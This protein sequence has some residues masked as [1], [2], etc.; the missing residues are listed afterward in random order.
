MNRQIADVEASRQARQRAE[1][2]VAVLSGRM[3]ATAAARQWKVSRKT[4]YAWTDRALR[5]MV[6][7][8][9]PRPGGR[10]KQAADPETVR[11][12]QQMAQIQNVVRVLEQ[13]QRIREV[14]MPTAEGEAAREKKA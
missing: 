2:I 6:A 7:A 10:P 4:F 14:L 12:R 1:T 3:Q 8:L 9:L 13:R 5:S 11:L